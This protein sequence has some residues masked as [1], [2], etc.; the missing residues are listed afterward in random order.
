MCYA[1]RIGCSGGAAFARCASAE[2]P[3][4]ELC[5]SPWLSRPKLKLALLEWYCCKS[6]AVLAENGIL[7]DAGREMSPPCSAEG[8]KGDT[9]LLS[10]RKLLYPSNLGSVD[11]GR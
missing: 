3:G 11:N 1:Y 2:S 6:K 9:L 4:S 10:V 8:G 5:N 7:V